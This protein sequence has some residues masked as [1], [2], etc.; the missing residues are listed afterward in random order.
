MAAYQNGGGGVDNGGGGGGGE[1]YKWAGDDGKEYSWPGLTKAMAAKIPKVSFNP[2]KMSD[3]P[4]PLAG[5]T[6]GG[7]IEQFLRASSD[8]DK[9]KGSKPVRVHFKG[10]PLVIYKA[11][12]H[13]IGEKR[14]P[15]HEEAHQAVIG[16]GIAILDSLP[17]MQVRLKA[18]EQDGERLGAI[19]FHDIWDRDYV[20][21]SRLLRVS[22]DEDYA[23]YLTPHARKRVDLLHTKASLR[24]KALLPWVMA[25]SFATGAQV[26]PAETVEACQEES[27]RFRQWL[28]QGVWS[29][30]GSP[31]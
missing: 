15:G 25:A 29:E 10:I 31:A 13:L 23:Y 4:V 9:A 26:L 20:P 28:A 16:H 21:K 11:W 12:F 14:F 18:H 3:G 22:Y 6:L 30:G 5:M 27:E 8:E 1:L 17:E 2:E 24:R 19:E 7:V